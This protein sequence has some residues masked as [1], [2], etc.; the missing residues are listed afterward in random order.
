MRAAAGSAAR[1]PIAEAPEV[2][3]VVHAARS[4][5]RT[6]VAT[7]VEGGSAPDA[8]DLAGPTCL[9]VG[10]E[11]HGLDPATV[12][13]C[14]AAVTVPMTGAVESVNVAIAGAVVLFEMARQRRSV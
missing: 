13:E 3:A 14:G 5:G 6:V 9:L 2:A 4:V 8:I 10:S 12:A 7:V 1:L 11:A